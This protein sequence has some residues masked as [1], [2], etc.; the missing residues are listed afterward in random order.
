MPVEVLPV[1]YV[2]VKLKI[3]QHF[4]GKAELR[5]A[6]AKAGPVVTDNGCF[7]LDWHFDPDKMER[8]PGGWGA[9]DDWLKTSIPGLLDTGLF[10]GMA[11]K[12]Y[13]GLEDGTVE[14][15]ASEK[16]H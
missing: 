13:F 10:V 9:A 6:K 16:S 11:R 14:E 2:P 3:E 7:I 5:M 15:V 12:A 1:A 4:G 8:Y